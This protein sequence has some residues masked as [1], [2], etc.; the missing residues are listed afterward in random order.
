MSSPLEMTVKRIDPVVGPVTS[1]VQQYLPWD[2][3]SAKISPP[4]G[5]TPIAMVDRTNNVLSTGI[6]NVK[7]RITP[8]GYIRAIALNVGY[9]N[10]TI[11]NAVKVQ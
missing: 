2:G 10:V 9:N 8:L 5:R 6:I 4:T 11:T 7:G 3:S 1:R